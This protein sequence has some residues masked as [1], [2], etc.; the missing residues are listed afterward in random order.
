[1]IKKMLTSDENYTLESAQIRG[2]THRINT[3][4][5]TPSHYI[6]LEKQNIITEF[7][8]TFQQLSYI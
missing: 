4:W 5:L 1:M 8:S 7:H 3:F 2:Q 6:Y